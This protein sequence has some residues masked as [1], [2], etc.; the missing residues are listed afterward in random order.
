M[1]E[2]HLEC[3]S[4]D[5]AVSAPPDPSHQPPPAHP[6]WPGPLCSA[7]PGRGHSLLTPPGG[8]FRRHLC[9][10][11]HTAS[12]RLCLKLPTPAQWVPQA[13]PRGTPRASSVPPSPVPPQRICCLCP[14]PGPA[15]P[16]RP[17]GARSAASSSRSLAPPEAPPSPGRGRSKSP[18]EG[19]SLQ[20][21]PRLPNGANQGA[22]CPA[23]SPPPG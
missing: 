6:S 22:R 10:Q 17:P 2:A 15:R 8:V 18:V 23:P 4:G 1:L 7:L 21:G 5:S 13:D 19:G 16:G 9:Q 20:R 3:R 12:S 14:R 11:G